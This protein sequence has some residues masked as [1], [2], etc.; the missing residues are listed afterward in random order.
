MTCSH[1]ICPCQPELYVTDWCEL[2][3]ACQAMQ[4][5][6]C[7]LLAHLVEVVVIRQMGGCHQAVQGQAD[8]AA[9][10][11]SPHLNAYILIG[12]MRT[13]HSPGSDCRVTFQEQCCNALLT[14]T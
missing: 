13:G 12:S 4:L 2:H 5:Q 14:C 1:V 7:G 9:L 10:Q 6:Y 3:C 8:D 11:L